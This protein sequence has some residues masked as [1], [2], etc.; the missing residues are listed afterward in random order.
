VNAQ[1]QARIKNGYPVNKATVPACEQKARLRRAW[2]FAAY[3]HCRA[4]LLLRERLGVMSEQ[5]YEAI[6]A[7]RD[8]IRHPVERA[9]AALYRHIGEHGC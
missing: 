2:S 6:R 1:Q 9:R 3:E 4:V 7:F 5:H 8:K